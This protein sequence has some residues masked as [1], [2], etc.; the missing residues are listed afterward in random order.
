M[1][2]IPVFIHSSCVSCGFQ[3]IQ[4]QGYNL[5]LIL[6]PTDTADLLQMQQ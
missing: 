6:V 4:E 1:L 2:V 3:L 5:D